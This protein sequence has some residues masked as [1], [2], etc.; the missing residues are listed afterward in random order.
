VLNQFNHLADIPLVMI[1]LH[2]SPSQ[3]AH[4]CASSKQFGFTLIE[5]MVVVGI[6]GILVS[7]AAPQYNK[8]QRKA[9]QSEAK[10]SL[11]GV[12]SLEKSFYSEYA[13]YI[14][15]FDAIGY[16]PEGAQRFYRVSACWGCGNGTWT[17]TVTGYSGTT[18]LQSYLDANSPYG[19]FWRF[20]GGDNCGPYMVGTWTFGN[21]PQ[22]F[23]AAAYGTLYFN[24]PLT[25][26]WVINQ[27]KVLVNCQ[28]GL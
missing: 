14:P 7:V 26:T 5:L 27:D 12:F 25:D 1:R 9:R 4:K 2:K 18:S 19:F 8:Y 11:S 3:D 17:G 21:D 20:P 28:V 16:S 23:G 22:I 6:L 24:A 13:A 10:I 15:A